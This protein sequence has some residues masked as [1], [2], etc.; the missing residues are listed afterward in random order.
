M[1]T[2]NVQLKNGFTSI[3]LKI[4]TPTFFFK[5]ICR[6]LAV[7]LLLVSCTTEETEQIEK[8]ATAFASAYYN[9]RFNNALALC[10]PESGKW[11]RYQASN[12]R[13]TDIDTYNNMADS[14]QCTIADVSFDDDSTATVLVD[15]RNY[16]VTD[17]IYRKGN[18][19]DK[20]Q[21][22]LKM[23]KKAN[24]WLVSLDSVLK[25]VATD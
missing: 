14:A 24:K 15:V 23:K 5:N 6:G 9:F 11:I 17:S 3:M 19:G 20:A 1:H 16:V 2:I 4:N 25:T 10:T 8:K 21:V 7:M 13:Q 12:V 18:V 22:T